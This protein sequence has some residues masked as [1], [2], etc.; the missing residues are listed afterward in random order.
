MLIYLDTCCLNRPYDDQSQLRIQLEAG[1]VLAI[2][3]QVTA[4]EIQ[5]ANSS[6]L[7]FE[8][9][10][11][12]D[13]NRRNGIHHFLSYSSSFQSLTSAIGQRGIELN[14]LGFKR[15]DA[16]HLAAAEALKVQAM[17]TTDDQLLRRAVQHSIHLTVS[18]LNPVQFSTT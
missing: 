5:L 4:G 17:L 7:Q 15:L 8:I 9:H 3:Q 2:L 12:A 13:Q 14:R 10:R 1:A 18:V 6:V 11:I 16:L